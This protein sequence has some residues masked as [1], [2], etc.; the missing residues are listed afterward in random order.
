MDDVRATARGPR[1][2]VRPGRDDKVV[3][4]W[5][6]WPSP[7]LC[8]AGRLLGRED[9]VT[10]PSATG[11]LLADLHL[12]DDGSLL[13]VSRDGRG[14]RHRGVLEDHGCVAG[15][16]L[17]LAGVTGDVAWLTRAPAVLDHALD[18][19]RADDG[20]FYDTADDAEALVAR[21][22]DPSDNASPR[23]PPP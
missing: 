1:E 11:T 16:F 12:R 18:R 20:G 13:R 6:G 21:P 23:A 14:R 10:S 7:S 2:R 19:F 4:A 15:G 5:N 9:L 8:D 22:R 3:A 17:A